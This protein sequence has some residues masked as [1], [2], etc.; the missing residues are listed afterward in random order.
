MVVVVVQWCGGEFYE[1]VDQNYTAS[2]DRGIKDIVEINVY[3]G[4]PPRFELTAGVDS[5]ITTDPSTTTITISITFLPPLRPV[6]Y[7]PRNIQNLG[8]QQPHCTQ[9]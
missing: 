4:E 8:N 6:L 3:T 7:L 2:W 5:N 9:Q 1:T